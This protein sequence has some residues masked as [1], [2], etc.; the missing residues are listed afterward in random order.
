MLV[1]YVGTNLA[2]L[3]GE[4]DKLLITLSKE[5]T[6]ITPEQIEQN[7]GISKDYNN[8]E[9]RSALVAKD[10]LK[11][12][13]I[14]QYFDENPK[15]NPIQ[16]TLAVLFGFFSNL[17]LAYYA[18]DKSEAGIANFLELKSPWQSREYLA[19]MRCYS[20]TKTMRI[21][22]RHTLRRRLF[23]GSRKLVAH[24]LRHTE[25]THFQHTPLNPIGH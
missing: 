11:A 17:M 3:T 13:R 16:V 20:G 10:V 18:P 25:G 1:D 22:E 2:R 19:A 8:F 24:E 9:L 4:L 7:I 15:A 21:I 14:I 23:Q 5:Q 12:N 6:R